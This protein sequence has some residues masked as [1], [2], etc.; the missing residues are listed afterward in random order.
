MI[1]SVRPYEEGEFD[2]P[3]LEWKIINMEEVD[4]VVSEWVRK[5]GRGKREE[6]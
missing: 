6:N 5:G 3:M 4:K 2:E 1:F